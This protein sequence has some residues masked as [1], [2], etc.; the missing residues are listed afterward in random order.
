[1]GNIVNS[2]KSFFIKCKRVWLILKKP[3]RKEYEQIAKVS[4]VGILVLG[5]LGFLISLVLKAVIK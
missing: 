4:A 2:A 3:S 5:I 1:M